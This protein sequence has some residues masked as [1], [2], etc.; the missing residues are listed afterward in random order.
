MPDCN[1]REPIGILC[2]P[3]SG[4]VKGRL[5]SMRA[6]AK[7]L[8]GARYREADD[9]QAI[10]AAVREFLQEGVDRLVV[11]AGDGTVHAVLDQLMAFPGAQLPALVLVPAGTTNMTASDLGL[12][13]APDRVFGRFVPALSGKESIKLVTR[14]VLRVES[15]QSG[16]Q[17]G[18]F[19]GAGMIAAGVRYFE[20]RVRSLGLTGEKASALVMIRFL[21]ALV[22]GRRKLP[23]TSTIV[24]IAEHPGE[25]RSGP[26][27]LT[28][29]TTLHRLLLGTKPYWG[30]EQGAMHVTSVMQNP[31]HLW[32]TLPW[33]LSGRGERLDSDSGC[34]SRNLA[35][36][37]LWI[38][39][40]YV[41]DGQLYQ[42]T[43]G[44]LRVSAERSI[45]FAVA[46]A[47]AGR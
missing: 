34:H 21:G 6:L 4:R 17:Y 41:I 40:D 11:I 18:M 39:G 26:L 43:G 3:S 2:N 30:G 44:P 25:V 24:R 46:T 33:L 47:D 27:L 42:N 8:P 7:T 16:I 31:R 12:R 10:R 23:A 13:G 28:F 9:L 29:A 19:F 36:L 38:E 14:R 22:L 45:D 32:R 35:S 1:V 15:G 37:D 5:D 20:E